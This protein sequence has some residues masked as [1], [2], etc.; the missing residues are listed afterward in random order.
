M[1]GGEVD[2]TLIAVKGMH[3]KNRDIRPLNRKVQGFFISSQLAFICSNLFTNSY[4]EFLC[5]LYLLTYGA[6]S[7][8][9]SITMVHFIII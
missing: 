9:L 5:C 3:A 2:K 4:A 8:E 7:L 6:I 1:K